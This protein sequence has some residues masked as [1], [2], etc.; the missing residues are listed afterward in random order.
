ME[1]VQKHINNAAQFASGAVT[2]YIWFAVFLAIIGVLTYYRTQ[3][4]KKKGSWRRMEQ[5]YS[6]DTFSPTIS[7]INNTDSR[8]KDRLFS[9]YIA[10]SYNSCCAGD[11]QD[12]YVS[13]DPLK[14]IIFHG[15]RVLD[16]AIYSVDGTAV[17][18]A[19]P[20]NSTTLK[21]TYNSLP[22]NKVLSTVRN[23]AFAG[24]T[25]PNPSDPLFLHFRIKS[26]RQDVYPVLAQ[27]IKSNFG[28][29]L[30]DATWGFEGRAG[31][32]DGSYNSKDL[33]NEPLLNLQNKVII[34]AYQEN[35]NYKDKENSFYELVNL[36]SGSA[37]FQQQRNHAIQYTPSTEELIEY[38]KNHIT[39][40]MPDWSEIDTNSPA[41]LHQTLGCQ[42]ICMNYQNLDK[43][44]KFYLNFFN[45][46]GTAFVLKPPYLRYIPV[47]LP[48]P[49]PP[50]PEHSFAPKK[51]DLPFGGFHM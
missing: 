27:A 3:I 7:S 28:P 33:G 34:I 35:D 47:K 41:M 31:I 26:N 50:P 9:Y 12:S 23:L 2:K 19:G 25:C 22:V 21:G 10:S 20:D 49:D 42:M 36:G 24:G 6:G 17:V 38:N 39:L 16:F 45:E 4:G 30:L 8:F 29:K 1:N 37:Y 48:C 32:G 11:F 44:M 51:Y 46:E 5:L 15:A 43:Q 18:A 13:V 14:E 40:T